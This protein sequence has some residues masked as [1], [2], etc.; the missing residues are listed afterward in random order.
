MRRIYREAANT[1]VWLDGVDD[2]WK[3]RTMLADISH[4]IGCGTMESYEEMVRIYSQMEEPGLWAALM[5]VFAHPYFFRV[6]VVQ[7]VAMSR[8][9]TVL[10]SEESLQWGHLEMFINL[11]SQDPFHATLRSSGLFMKDHAPGGSSPA[12]I[13]G[14]LRREA[15][16]NSDGSTDRQLRLLLGLFVDLQATMPVDRIYSLLALLKADFASSAPWLEPDYTK[17]SEQVYTD[18]ARHLMEASIQRM[19]QTSL[20][21]RGRMPSKGPKPPVM[22]TGLDKRVTAG[23]ASLTL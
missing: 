5:N 21:C 8:S 18:V 7:E 3:A 17:P 1:I 15:M 19:Q 4:E 9:V 22:G 23:D 13:M 11:Q 6:R 14:T 20:I 12:N 16:E 2:S 10:A